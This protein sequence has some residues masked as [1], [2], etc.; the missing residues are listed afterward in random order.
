METSLEYKVTQTFYLYSLI[1]SLCLMAIR[2]FYPLRLLF[3]SG[4]SSLAA[5]R[6]RERT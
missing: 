6:I 3:Q 5:L 1:I 2:L 4:F